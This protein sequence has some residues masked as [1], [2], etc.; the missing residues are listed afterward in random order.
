MTVRRPPSLPLDTM[1]QM[2]PTKRTYSTT[3]EAGAF[4]AG[5]GKKMCFKWPTVT[6]PPSTV[7]TPPSVTAIA[8][9]STP[10]QLA[11]LLKLGGSSTQQAA[12]PNTREF[13]NLERVFDEFEDVEPM[14]LAEDTEL[15]AL[16]TTVCLDLDME[17]YW[18]D[19]QRKW[20]FDAC[21]L[22]AQYAKMDHQHSVPSLFGFV[23]AVS[24]ILKRIGCVEE[25]F[26]PNKLFTKYKMHVDSNPNALAFFNCYVRSA[27]YRLVELKGKIRLHVQCKM[28]GSSDLTPYEFTPENVFGVGTFQLDESYS[29]TETFSRQFA[30]GRQ[31][32]LHVRNL[33]CAPRTVLKPPTVKES[34][35]QGMC[36]DTFFPKIDQ[37]KILAK[38]FSPPPTETSTEVNALG[39]RVF[40]GFMAVLV[41]LKP[42]P[43]PCPKDWIQ[44]VPKSLLY[45]GAFSNPAFPPGIILPPKTQVAFMWKSFTAMAKHHRKMTPELRPIF[46]WVLARALAYAQEVRRYYGVSRT[47]EHLVQYKMLCVAWQLLQLM[48]VHSPE[49]YALMIRSFCHASNTGANW[50][51]VQKTIQ[52]TRLAD[53]EEHD[54]NQGITII[55]AWDV[56]DN[57]PIRRWIETHISTKR[58]SGT[59]AWWY[60]APFTTFVN[61]L[62]PPRIQIG[63]ALKIQA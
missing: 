35:N 29:L 37:P 12:S 6:T 13:F 60:L 14:D 17:Q 1:H 2:R 18:T 51:C 47:S 59:H 58:C 49:L 48:F 54:A 38:Q 21:Y 41:G 46:G 61:D 50:Y 28:K 45:A 39:R 23:G 11:A 26:C 19:L 55:S 15:A 3:R 32:I 8:P 33:F 44:L 9:A 22:P 20:Q 36:F 25:C 31:F 52:C 27:T 62:E 10:K 42:S 57:K 30:G 7:K 53:A 40:T 4:S 5:T 24:N 43:T 16:A 34:V 56:T 63:R